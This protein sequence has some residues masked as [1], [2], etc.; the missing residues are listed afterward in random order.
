MRATYVLCVSPVLILTV[1]CAPMG[2]A[3]DAQL[4][5]I[6]ALKSIWPVRQHDMAKNFDLSDGSASR[7]PPPGDV[8][9]S[10]PYDAVAMQPDQ[11]FLDG[12]SN[13]IQLCANMAEK[14]RSAFY[15]NRT[16]TI[17]IAT[18]GI[19]AGAIIVPALA[20]GS[21]SAAWVAGVG[22][23]AGAAN[24]AQLSLNSQGMSAASSA[25]A[26]VKLT[27]KIDAQ[28]AT[29][30]KV[31]T[32]LDGTAFILRLR[33]ICL[34]SPL[35]DATDAPKLTGA[36]EKSIAQENAEIAELQKKAAVLEYEIA[37]AKADTETEV[38]RLKNLRG[39]D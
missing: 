38:K 30:N 37:K 5:Q 10:K 1:G 11:I 27:E 7:K 35:P 16:W 9:I 22:G 31:Q 12:L 39:K 25:A 23:V 14:Y 2:G 36:S 19:I 8:E 28:L 4:S 20:A 17:G 13:E 21:A 24:A 32:G 29:L 18:V 33:A 34:F 6:S 26:Y 15:D 3:T